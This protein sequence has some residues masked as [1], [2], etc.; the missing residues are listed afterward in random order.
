MSYSISN[1]SKFHDTS[2]CVC[3]YR[4][5]D[6]CIT[7]IAGERFRCYFDSLFFLLTLCGSIDQCVDAGEL[8]TNVSHAEF[9]LP[10]GIRNNSFL[11]ISLYAFNFF[12]HLHAVNLKV[13]MNFFQVSRRLSQINSHLSE[14]FCRQTFSLTTVLPCR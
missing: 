3:S 1:F 2:V 7:V 14:R 13:Q 9:Q 4:I 10:H 12:A 5:L 8:S 6:Q 11:S